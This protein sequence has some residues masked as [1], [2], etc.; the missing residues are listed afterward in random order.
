M[1]KITKVYDAKVL[2]HM[3]QIQY[4]TIRSLQIKNNEL[5]SKIE[6]LEQLLRFNPFII[7]VKDDTTTST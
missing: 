6:H 4:E 7:K 5:Q 2:E 3:N 1:V